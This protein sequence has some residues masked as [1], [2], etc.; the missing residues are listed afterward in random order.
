MELL[1]LPL[2]PIKTRTTANGRTE[3]LDDFRKKYVLLTS[4]EWVRQQFLWYLVNEKKYPVSLI[5]VEKGL[6]IN[7][8]PK[9]FDAIIYNKKGLP[10]VLIEYKSH[11]ISL[12]Q[13]VFE[14]IAMYNLQL[15]V[16]FLIISNGLQHFCCIMDYEKQTFRFL[17][18]IPAYSELVD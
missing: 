18:K 15:Q 4:E 11:E 13:K 9:R 3:V 5:S 2:H 14:Q 6:T 17:E 8:L 10:V 1:N 16:K 7:R 12:S